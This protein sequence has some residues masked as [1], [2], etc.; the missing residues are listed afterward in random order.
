MIP[1]PSRRSVF[2]SSLAL[3]VLSLV[4]L[5]A[6]LS[7]GTIEADPSAVACPDPDSSECPAVSPTPEVSAT[8]TPDSD[9]TVPP[10]P[11]IPDQPEISVTETPV[12][13][14]ID[15]P[16]E[17]PT[18]MPVPPSLPNFTMAVTTLV[19]P[20]PS[21]VLAS[22]SNPIPVSEGES[23]VPDVNGTIIGQ[24]ATIYIGEQGLNVTHALNQANAAT[25]IDGAPVL[26]SI[27][28]WPSAALV[29]TTSPAKTIDLGLN[30]TSLMVDPVNF[31]SYT[32]S[33][34]LLDA[35]GAAANAT[36]PVFSA[37]DPT[38]DIRVWDY[39]TATDVTGTSVP[40]GTRLRFRID[41]NMYSAVDLDHRS[42]INPF[43]DG[44][45]NVIVKNESGTVLSV[46][47]NGSTDEDPSVAGPNTVLKNFVYAQPYFWGSYHGYS[48]KTNA[49]DNGV[50]IYPDGTYT[51]KAESTLNHMKDNYKSAGA[52]YAGKTVSAT[53]TITLASG[54][55]AP[56]AGFT[57]TP[58][59]GTA[60]LTVVFTD[61]STGSPTGW[62]WTFGDGDETNAT[63]QNPIHTYAKAGFYSVS[64]NAT[65]AQ[66]SNV[67]VRTNYITVTGGGPSAP[68]A[69]FAANVTYGSP[70][71][72]V[73][74]SDLSTNSPIQWNWSF[75][76]GS[77][78]ILK[79]PEH[80]YAGSGTYTVSLNATN[81][82]GSNTTT[83]T[84]YITA[85]E[86]A[87]S[88]ETVD[89]SAEMGDFTSLALDSGDNPHI[90]YLDATNS[91]LRYGSKNSG[92]WS[93]GNVD[94]GTLAG[95]YPSL[96]M[97]TSDYPRISYVGG[98][99]DDL[100]YAAW[101]GAGW[102]IET[103]DPG[104]ANWEPTSLRLDSSGNPRIS[105]HNFSDSDLRLA[106]WNGASWS[107]ETVDSVGDV[108]LDS[109]LV[110][111]SDDHP[112]ISYYDQTNGALKYAAWNGASWDI[113]TV[114]DQDDTGLDTSLALDGSGNPRISYYSLSNGNLKYAAKNSG[115]WTV[116]TVDS[117]GD[118]GKHTSLSLDGSDYPHIS[119][120]DLQYDDLKYASWDG[121]TWVIETVDG[122]GEVGWYT[123]LALD[124]NYLPHISY[125]DYTNTALKY[126]TKGSGSAPVANFSATPVSGTAPLTVVFTDTSAGSPTAWN[127]TFGDGDAT[128]A[129]VQNPVHTYTTAG[130]YTVSLN[131]T[132]ANGS[133]VSVRTDYI[134]A[135]GP[136]P[137]PDFTADITTGGA[138]LSV[139]FTDLS[140]GSPTGW[141][142]FFG[143]EEFT[144][145]WTEVNASAGWPDR[146]Y[147][148]SVV[149][150]DGSV[151]I[152]G[153]E[154]SVLGMNDTWRS[155]DNGLTW[156]EQSEGA[157]WK[158]RSSLT[159]VALPDNSI[160]VMAG[161]DPDFTFHND[162][163]RSTDYGVTW[164][165]MNGAPGWLA[166]ANP[167]SVA[168]E[169]GTIL[170]LGGGDQNV[171]MNDIWRSTDYGATWTLVNA[172]PGW[173]ARLYPRSLHSRMTGF[174]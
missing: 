122:A 2:S 125:Y 41:T 12:P 172:S 131:A 165:L 115:T 128:N 17:T 60:P 47:Y 50:A 52:D 133:D 124:S 138:P 35:G 106:S 11:D 70:P 3:F 94:T 19:T 169:D 33:W 132:N 95:W 66:G 67:S 36:H 127:W 88:V 136:K 126:A 120:W 74:F 78:S 92:T 20:L 90:S 30:Y 97:D 103:V 114:D 73:K 153:G 6:A 110:L 109:S 56:V 48:W 81:G 170:L 84:G 118:V 37:L 4:I 100:R 27:G 137:A 53:Y 89:D 5:G 107:L 148:T 139:Q 72:A 112:R 145:P 105:Y 64:L 117:V 86:S 34:Y 39:D 173:S 44:F 62:N 149:T 42:P 101:N 134:T 159:G 98:V 116:E 25:D 163:W 9:P 61:T 32:G 13:E 147:H 164:T 113:E 75:G 152:M 46:L 22:N 96:V 146:F 87:W 71:F 1:A 80:V 166:R 7:T 59:F 43:T 143:D 8:G 83:K 23:P 31:V 18:V 38:L 85:G 162:T 151:Y 24:G 29:G 156:T 174:F 168:L 171:L 16:V 157:L 140:A 82:A 10:Q 65:N 167:S 14:P 69:D 93:I 135:S 150:P 91:Y 21:P 26:T 155:T 63:V 129:T 99:S 142:W 158:A 102:N 45:I 51:V 58:T 123:S 49:T 119:Y 108:G 55:I 104:G 154:G 68:V 79:E 76:D 111:D 15:N 144:Q 161:V 54:P 160:V 130:T 141:A 40:S 77:Y 57:G 121:T 28:W